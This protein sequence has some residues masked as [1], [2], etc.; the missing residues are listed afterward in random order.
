[1]A[2]VILTKHIIYLSNNK[3]IER[4]P[5]T[6]NSLTPRLLNSNHDEIADREHMI[7]TVQTSE[8]GSLGPP[9]LTP[10]RSLISPVHGLYKMGYRKS[11]GYSWSQTCF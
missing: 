1:M 6:P 8:F 9:P 4:V 5:R 7:Q 3:L 10:P 11:Q 2:V